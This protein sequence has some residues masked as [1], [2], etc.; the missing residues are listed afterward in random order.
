MPL[1]R[2]V[3]WT[4]CVLGCALLFGSVVLAQNMFRDDTLQP[5]QPRY[6]ANGAYRLILRPVSSYPYG[7]PT[8]RAVVWDRGHD[9]QCCNWDQDNVIWY[10]LFDYGAV[11]NHQSQFNFDGD[12]A[13]MQGDGNFVLYNAYGYPVWATNTEN[14]PDAWLNLQDDANLVVYSASNVP[15]WSI[16]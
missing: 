14:H 6:S 7:V 5:G 10:S 11:G 9:P 12:V 8:A 3:F 16:Y 1:R 13:Y 4:A 2:P 15:L